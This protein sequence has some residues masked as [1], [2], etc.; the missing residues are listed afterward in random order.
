MT[1]F[2]PHK[3]LMLLHRLVDQALAPLLEPMELE[4]ATESYVTVN[5]NDLDALAT[6]SIGEPQCV[7]VGF[8]PRA[9]AHGIMICEPSLSSKV[10]SRIWRSDRNQG[11]P[12]TQVEGEI[13]RQFLAR[14]VG[15]WGESWANES[16]RAIP[17]FTMAG[18]IAMVQQQMTDDTWHVA[19]TIV[20]DRDG[21]TVGVLL[22]CY[23]QAV[24]CLLEQEARSTMWRS[25]IARGLTEAER[26]RLGSRL[27][28]PLQDVIVTAPTVLQQNMTLGMLNSLERG[29]VIAFDTDTEGG[30]SLQI[31]GRS[32]TGILAA[33]ED[34]LA[35]ALTQPNEV[36]SNASPSSAPHPNALHAPDQGISSP[37]FASTY[38]PQDEINPENE[39]DLTG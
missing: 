6:S 12:L 3:T 23:P 27:S 34:H 20:R 1:P 31:L 29:D 11:A 24:L 21:S 37:D 35:L 38:N 39:W 22:F 15:A 33:H 2:P 25:R 28:G 26:I 30:I 16:I 18:S 13:L 19:R 8:G 32:V 10:L 7:L 9:T 5:R 14:I 17:E 36:G 4:H